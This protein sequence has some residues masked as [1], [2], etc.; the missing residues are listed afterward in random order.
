MQV[1][2]SDVPYQIEPELE[3][4][5]MDEEGNMLRVVFYLKSSKRYYTYKLRG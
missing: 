5:E 3:S 4:W 1:F 2:D